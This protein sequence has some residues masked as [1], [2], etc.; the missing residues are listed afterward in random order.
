MATPANES[1]G[2]GAKAEQEAATANLL[3]LSGAL[4]VVRKGDVVDGKVLVEHL[5]H[6]DE[7]GPVGRQIEVIRLKIDETPCRASGETIIADSTDASA[8]VSWGMEAPAAMVILVGLTSYSLCD[9]VF[10]SGEG[11]VRLF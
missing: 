10:S 2:V 3:Q 9:T 5:A 7:H 1:E 6:G 4:E 11:T 8:S